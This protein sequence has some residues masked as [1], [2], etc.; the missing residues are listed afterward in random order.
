MTADAG[1]FSKS[2]LH[3]TAILGTK[4][5]SIGTSERIR[6]TTFP[7]FSTIECTEP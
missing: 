1:N 7:R 5:V 2:L 4:V 3:G 6:R